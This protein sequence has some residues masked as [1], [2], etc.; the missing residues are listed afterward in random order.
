MNYNN[1]NLV[2]VPLEV[3]TSTIRE[4]VASELQKAKEEIF[5]NS[6]EE[7]MDKFLSIKDVCELLSVSD[8][9]LYNW[10]RDKILMKN[11]IGG[12]VYYNKSDV[13]AILNPLKEVS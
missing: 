12:R 7:S 3:M 4:I 1:I 11:K 9:T 10:N 5:Q 2:N 8:G 6:S 13:L